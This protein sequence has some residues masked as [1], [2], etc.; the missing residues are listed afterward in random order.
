MVNRYDNPAQAEFINTYVPIPFEQ[1]YTLG[2]QAKENVDQ[3]LK[4]YS[5]AL[6][7]W[8]EFQSPSA[9]DTKAYYDET[10]GR[11]LPVAEELSKNLDMIKTAEGRSRI[12]SA[13]N[14]V[15]RAKLS[16]LRQ[17]AE[18]LKERQK[19]NQRLMLE[20]KYNPLWHDVDFTG[21][22]TLDSGIYNDVS[23]LGY[24]SIKDLTDKY[25]NN[26][27]D[28]LIKKENGFLYTGV[29]GDQIKQILDQN[30]SGILS[31]PEAQMHMQIYM[32]QNPNSTTEDAANAFMQKAY[33]DNQEYIRQNVAADPFELEALRQD[34]ANLRAGLKKGKTGK[35]S[36]APASVYDMFLADAQNND[37]RLIN[38]P[39]VFSRVREQQNFA[40]ILGEK[41]DRAVEELEVY[42]QALANGQI[43]Q[44]QYDRALADYTREYQ[45]SSESLAKSLQNAYRDDIREI[46]SKSVGLVPNETNQTKNPIDYYDGAARTL[47][48]LMQPASSNDLSIYN[49][50]KY[51][52][53]VKV[54]Y[55]DIPTD[56]Y[57]SG[58]SSGFKLATDFVNKLMG[59]NSKPLYIKD[60]NNKERDFTKDLQNGVIKRVL[61]IPT[62]TYSSLKDSNTQ[63]VPKMAQRMTMLIPKS[64]LVAAGYDEDRL[65]DFFEDNLGVKG[66]RNINIK[67]ISTNTVD[68]AFGT[69]SSGLWTT[70]YDRIPNTGTDTYYA[71]DVTADINPNDVNRVNWDTVRDKNRAGTSLA[72]NT[73]VLRQSDTYSTDY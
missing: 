29:T 20:G 53:T 9:A 2:K 6:D 58:T 43:T 23:P 70:T 71:V 59:V 3:A 25:V 48:I 30:R 34:N 12:Y 24:Q 73:Y 54:N 65:N 10:Y 63:D 4:D 68:N 39:D 55:N 1:L 64:S 5:T 13:I 26:L 27:K 44:K 50:F 35:E 61:V 32:K 22:S 69:E 49:T 57:V 8:A 66:T 28:S 31:T 14:N 62:N 33:T 40:N 72:K 15:D 16:M 41:R 37:R 46:F 21:Y 51:G 19:V 52:N 60:N 42:K 47:D 11:A 17:S 36:E 56:A 7:K 38:S 18:G 67:A 45:Q